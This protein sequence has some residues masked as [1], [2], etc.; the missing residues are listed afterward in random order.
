MCSS[1][2]A[3]QNSFSD[4][5]P[6]TASISIS[7]ARVHA[8]LGE[9]GAGKSTLIK[10]LT[11]AYRRD[12]GTLVLDGETIDPHIRF[13]RR[14]SESVR[15]IRKSISCRISPWPKTSFLAGIPAVRADT[16]AGDES[17]VADAACTIRARYRSGS[18]ARA[19]L[20]RSQQV[21]AIARAVDL[22]GKVLVLDE[23]TASL[24][25]HE[26]DLLFRIVGELKA[27]GLGIVF[28][29][30]F[31]EQVYRISD[32]ITVLRNGRLVGMRDTASLERRD[33]VAMMLG[34]ELARRLA[35][36]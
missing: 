1:P 8:L 4:R 9:N 29:N 6:S 35:I 15:S 13:Q 36:R 34:R 33:L 11:G 7:G 14:S 19:I 12:S 32:R 21:V 22:S 16:N 24:D 2:R 27:R 10:C 31:L 20:G 18:T 17:Q 23:P 3:F 26:V 30:S 5:K 25:A 28:I